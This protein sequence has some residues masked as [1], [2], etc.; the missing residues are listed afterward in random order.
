MKLRLNYWFIAFILLPVS[1]N[2]FT[3]EKKE[4][5]VARVKIVENNQVIVDT[6]IYKNSPELEKELQ[7]LL[8]ERDMIILRSGN[9][10]EEGSVRLEKDIMV[11]RK[12]EIDS[13]M[14]EIQKNMKEFKIKLLESEEYANIREEVKAN[15]EKSRIEMDSMR[16]RIMKS[17]EDFTPPQVFFFDKG[18]EMEKDSKV[19][20]MRK[21]GSDKVVELE[22]LTIILRNNDLEIIESDEKDEYQIKSSDGK[23]I[24]IVISEEEEKSE[25]KKKK[26]K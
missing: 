18:D 7:E 14:T 25:M 6:T 9:P 21:D 5:N 15:W 19:I 16:V 26:K 8:K 4:Q 2:S 11:F 24:R 22:D 17:F 1:M 12:N 20:I 23:V 3:Q 10:E 13:M